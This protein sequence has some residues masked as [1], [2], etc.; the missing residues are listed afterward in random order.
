METKSK[1]AARERSR[2]QWRRPTIK[3][4]TR[5]GERT[6]PTTISASSPERHASDITELAHPCGEQQE[7]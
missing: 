5:L 1:E 3:P 6:T 7:G 2:G 4:L